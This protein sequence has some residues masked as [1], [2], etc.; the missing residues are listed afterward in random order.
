VAS[1]HDPEAPLV[2][3]EEIAGGIPGAEQVIFEESGHYPFIEEP[4]RF[5]S[6]MKVFLV[7]YQARP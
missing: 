7:Q 5:V 6:V 4:A 1:S 2:C 3:S